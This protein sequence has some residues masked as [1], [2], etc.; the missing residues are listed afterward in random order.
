MS[1]YNLLANVFNQL[2][3]NP[4]SSPQDK[5]D[6]YELKTEFEKIYGDKNF[7]LVPS[8]GSSKNSDQSIKLVA[9]HHDA[10]MNSAKRVNAHFN[11][12]GTMPW[13]CVLPH[14][15]V[16]AL[17]IYARAFC[18]R[19]QVHSLQW[20]PAVFVD[21]ILHFKIQLLSLVPTQVFDL[22]Q[23][24][25]SA[26]EI[27]KHVFV[28]GA[29]LDPKLR[30]QILA[31]GWPV[32]ETYGMTETSSMI[33]MGEPH[34]MRLLPDVE[35][36]LDFDLLKIKA[37]S[38]LT[39]TIQKVAGQFEINKPQGGWFLTDDRAEL[40]NQG[41]S[42]VLKLLG[43]DSDFIKINAEGVSLGQLRQ[44]LGILEGAALFALPNDRSEYEM[45]IAH[46]NLENILEVVKKYN[47][48][49]RPFEKI[50]KIYRV[51]KLPR[52]EI[53]KIQYPQLIESLKGL[54]HEKI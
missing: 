46:E 12:D 3:M 50:R 8:S 32:V 7:F 6:H 43:R 5:A 39:C 25:L 17:A 2:L 33:A 20:D 1:P 28:G 27:V 49:V 13:G 10:V 36:A 22:V 19:S 45:A 42:V 44:T 35:V 11:L 37:D 15:H 48:Q 29:K 53:G 41:Q 16:A 51:S 54:S 18:T 23:L 38:L 26:P 14:F 21:W 47:S 31:L 30:E 52:T 40:S 24:N 9:L 34:N 4:R